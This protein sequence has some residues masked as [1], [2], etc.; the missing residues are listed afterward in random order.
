MEKENQRR[1][2]VIKVKQSFEW[3]VVFDY[4]Q[5]F[6]MCLEAMRD[7]EF[8]KKFTD[9]LDYVSSKISMPFEGNI[10]QIYVVVEQEATNEEYEKWSE[11]ENRQP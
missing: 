3:N 2:K 4:L 1:C 11:D 10:K 7:E 9:I 6:N 5:M 8:N